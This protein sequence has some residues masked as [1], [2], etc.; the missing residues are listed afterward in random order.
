MVELVDNWFS[1][2]TEFDG[3]PKILR[4]R[5]ELKSL[6]GLE[7]HPNLLRII[8][9]YEPRDA[10]GLPRPEIHDNMVAFE[11]AI[12]DRLEEEPLCIFYCVYMHDGVKDWSA[13]CSDIERA[14][15]VISEALADYEN[16]PVV[17]DVSDDP[18]WEDYREMVKAT[19]EH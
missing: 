17:I 14:N 7:S 10:S 19:G 4:G 8:W 15:N 16:F 3:M 6:I 1:V 18:D 2:K 12:F 13:Y 9:G 11:N 5:A